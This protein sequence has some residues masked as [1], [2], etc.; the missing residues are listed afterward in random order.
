VVE[1]RGVQDVVE[2]A[3]GVREGRSAIGLFKVKLVSSGVVMVQ[4]GVKVEG[5]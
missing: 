3:R 4:K 5:R 1:A 2:E